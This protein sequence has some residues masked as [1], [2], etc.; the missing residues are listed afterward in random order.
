MVSGSATSFT[1]TAV[2]LTPHGSVCRSMIS[3]NFWLIDSRCESRSS[4]GAWPSTLRNVVCD[5]SEV[6]LRKFSTFTTAACGSTTRKYTTAS[7]VTGTLSR[8]IT[9]CRSTLMVTTRKSIRTIRS[10]I[11]MRKISP[12]PFAP[13]NF[14]RR[15]IT[16]RS[17]S[18][19][20]RI[21]CGRMMTA[22]MMRGM[23]Q[24]INFGSASSNC[25][26]L[27]SFGFQF[28]GQ[29]VYGGDLGQFAFF[30]GCVA[31]CVPIF[32]FDENPAAARIDWRQCGHRFS[33][34]CLCSHFH[35]QQL[36]AQPFSDDENKKGR[37]NECCR[38]NVAERQTI[39]WIGAVEEHERA[40]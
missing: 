1:S 17:Y 38:N 33:N 35:R 30:D 18:R 13:S 11:G 4:K 16:P 19:K 2:T 36:R 21:A 40:D 31:D 23:A 7:T 37:S 34:Q 32:T 20:M 14:P 22:R 8:V 10:T 27:F 6:A 25:I 39:E 26:A 5:I 28:Y 12:G 24:L 29:S 15:K 9:S 3:C